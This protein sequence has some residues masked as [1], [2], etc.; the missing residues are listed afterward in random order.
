MKPNSVQIVDRLSAVEAIKRL[1]EDD[2]RFLNRLIVERIKLISQARS[3]SLM[4]SFAAGDRVSFNHSDGRYIE[5]VVVRLHKKTIRVETDDGHQWN[6]SP[7]LL[8]LES[9]VDINL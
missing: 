9:S 6:V 4:A 7:G 5:G 1:G 8:H 2:L 3:T